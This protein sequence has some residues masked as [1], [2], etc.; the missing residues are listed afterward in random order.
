MDLRVFKRYGVRGVDVDGVP[1]VQ[2][3]R[4]F[5]PSAKLELRHL[6]ITATKING[7]STTLL[8]LT[9]NAIFGVQEFPFPGLQSPSTD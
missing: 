3:L 8:Q 1:G 4:K 2:D 9:D 5:D 7:F 6:S